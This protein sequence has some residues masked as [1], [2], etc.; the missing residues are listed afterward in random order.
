MQEIIEIIAYCSGADG[1]SICEE[2]ELEELF[3]DSLDLMEISLAIED[4]LGVSISD[5]E[6]STIKTIG[7]IDKIVKGRKTNENL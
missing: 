5:D 1:K 3:L 4:Q 6:W 7:D 2:T